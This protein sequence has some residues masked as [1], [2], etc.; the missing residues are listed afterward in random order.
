MG[1]MSLREFWQS[2]PR[3]A[4]AALACA[5]LDALLYPASFVGLDITSGPGNWFT[6]SVVVIVGVGVASVLDLWDVQRQAWRA[7]AQARLPTVMEQV[8]GPLPRR[9]RILVWALIVAIIAVVAAIVELSRTKSPGQV[10]NAAASTRLFA[11]VGVAFGILVSRQ[12]D[13]AH[14]RRQR[15]GAQAV[16]IAARVAQHVT[17]DHPATVL[18]QASAPA[19]SFPPH[20]ARR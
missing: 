18:W 6:L 9:P 1:I 5:A 17:G 10:E 19:R 13:T 20:D 14:R 2:A 11:A 7:A 16:A 12:A 8:T 4:R 15:L 3:G